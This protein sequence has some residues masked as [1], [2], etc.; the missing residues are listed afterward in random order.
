MSNF[1]SFIRMFSRGDEIYDV[2][3]FKGWEN[4]TKIKVENNTIQWQAGK[5]LPHF[6]RNILTKMFINPNA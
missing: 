3:W 6:V 1:D 4:W 2:F 5:N